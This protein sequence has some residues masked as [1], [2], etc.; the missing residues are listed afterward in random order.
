L[1]HKPNRR[2]R[3]QLGLPPLRVSNSQTG[4]NEKSLTGNI[5]CS[6]DKEEPQVLVLHQERVVRLPGCPQDR[7]LCPLATLRRLYAKSVDHCNVE[8]LCRVKAN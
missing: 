5:P 3:D 7:D 1:A 2:V 8:E 4:H 6:C